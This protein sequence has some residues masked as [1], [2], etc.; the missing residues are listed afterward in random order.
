VRR[1]ALH[2]RRVDQV[3]DLL[4]HQFMVGRDSGIE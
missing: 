4:L 2:G 1:H 3:I